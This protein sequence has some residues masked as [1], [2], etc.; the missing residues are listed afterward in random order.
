[1]KLKTA[2]DISS[3]LKFMIE[4][5]EL[6]SNIGKQILLNLDFCND[7]IELNREF[8]AILFMKNKIAENT[9]IVEDFNIKLYRIKDIRGS[10]NNLKGRN[11]LDD[12]ELFEIKNFC[13]LSEE[14]RKLCDLYR[15]HIFEIPHL[16]QVIDILDPEG[17]K[18]P[19]FY[20]YDAYSEELHKLRKKIKSLGKENIAEIEK[21]RFSAEQI[22]DTIRQSLS[23]D[24][25]VHVDKIITALEKIAKLDILL[26]KSIQTIEM[27]LCKPEITESI[28]S[29][30]SLINPQIDELLKFQNKKYQ[31]ID[32]EI[33]KSP[34]LITGANMSGK[35]VLLKTVA[36]AQYLA[37]FGFFIPAKEA[38]VCLVDKIMLC[39]DDKQN[40]LK[41]LSS[42]AAEILEINNII[43][44]SKNNSNVLVLI[45]ELAKTTN[46]VEG[47]AIVNAVLEILDQQEIRSLITTHY[48]DI[49]Y[50]TRRLRVKGLKE[51]SAKINK[52][53]IN[54]YIDYSLIETEE[55]EVPHEAIRI[56]E[57]LGVD[58]EFISEI[59]K[60]LTTNSM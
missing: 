51:E 38:K 48:S 34:C 52:D 12:I 56:A 3:S 37:Q 41:G 29:Y 28:T 4:N 47:S 24:L 11:T 15:I 59:R 42:F 36:L 23:A 43:Q 5:L 57:I 1:M 39:M 18:V 44:E 9:K 31:P 2:I 55:T 49:H 14:I 58:G 46:P 32:I 19:T 16:Q 7:K 21:L 60:Q 10:L 6:Q 25:F 20:V 22:E 26:S 50:K 40:E 35:T 8:E 33:R 13:I 53:N 17:N 30:K 27:N 54:D 45:D